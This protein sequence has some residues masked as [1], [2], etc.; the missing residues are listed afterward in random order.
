MLPVRVA[1]VP[2]RVGGGSEAGPSPEVLLRVAAA[3]QTQVARDVAP[4]WGVSAA[5]SPF[6][7]LERV[8]PGYFPLVIVVGAKLPL[9]RQ[10]VHLM[11]GGQPA[12]LVEYG[13]ANGWTA[14]ASHE[15]IEMVC[16]PSGTRTAPGPSLGD[17]I[18]AARAPALAHL[19]E[20][21][22][23]QGRVEY[24]ME[25][26]DPCENSTYTIDGVTVSDFVTPAFYE[27]AERPGDRY[28]FTGRCTE[29]L[30]VLR[31]GYITWRSAEPEDGIWQAYAPVGDAPIEDLLPPGKLE[32]ERIADVPVTF[33]RQW[34]D[35][36]QGAIPTLRGRPP[37]PHSVTAEYGAAEQHGAALT[38]E[39][40]L[41]LKQPGFGI[42]YGD[43]RAF[44]EDARIP[45]W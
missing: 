13:E 16:D 28:S 2:Y 24:L 14:D 3:L 5:V 38:R 33:S 7:S 26:C 21:Y 25:V 37:K 45:T 11:T 9:N 6:L 39:L 20:K 34:V 15:L 30:R 17:A 35:A 10:G 42:R 19:E 29:P 23:P 8:P 22:R 41:L 4:V 32:I 36:H 27:P 12:A 40:E 31:G 44:E 18:A 43:L 1:V